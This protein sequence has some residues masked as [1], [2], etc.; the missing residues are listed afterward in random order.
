M[1]LIIK[2]GLSEPPT[3]SLA[4]R[5]ITLSARDSLHLSVLFESKKEKRDLYFSLLRDKG[6]MDFVEDL[7]FEEDREE[8]IRIDTEYNY[9][10]TIK[11]NEINFTNIP[12]ILGQISFLKSLRHK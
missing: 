11:T 8:G 3:L 7:I 9:P 6:L 2:A 10:L 12:N 5:L 4:L 1:N